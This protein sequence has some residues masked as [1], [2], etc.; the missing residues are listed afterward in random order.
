MAYR[1][2]PTMNA[3]PPIAR[4]RSVLGAFLSVSDTVPIQIVVSFLTVALFEGR[5]LREYAEM[6]NSP[7]STMSRHLLDLGARN[8]KKE[9]GYGLIEQTTDVDDLRK[10][11]YRLT[12]KGRALVQTVS[13]LMEK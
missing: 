7:Q 9:P 5:S 12:P 2:C 4:A 6:T 1:S 3:H 8:R 13:E 11:V 10:N